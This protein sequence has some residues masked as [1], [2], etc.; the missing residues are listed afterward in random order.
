MQPSPWVLHLSL[1][2]IMCKIFDFKRIEDEYLCSVAV[3]TGELKSKTVMCFD[4]Q[5]KSVAESQ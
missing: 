3:Q 5:H 1:E 2:I 4:L